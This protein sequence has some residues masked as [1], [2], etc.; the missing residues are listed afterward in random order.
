[1]HS[2]RAESSPV[3]LHGALTLGAPHPALTT[4]GGS[5]T[6][7]A[8]LAPQGHWGPSACSS[9]LTRSFP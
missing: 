4:Q 6:A 7:G 9:G 1:M 5:Q 2:H 3:L 8:A